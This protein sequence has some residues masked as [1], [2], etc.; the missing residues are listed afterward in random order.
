MQYGLRLASPSLDVLPLAAIADAVARAAATGGDTPFHKPTYQGKFRN[1]LEWVV[2]DARE[3][4]LAVTDQ[5]GKPGT[6]DEAI[7]RAKDNG[8]YSEVSK[9][10][11]EEAAS[12]DVDLDA[13]HALCVY[14]TL[15]NLNDWAGEQGN[16]FAISR[17][18]W[19]DERGWVEPNNAGF[20]RGM[21]QTSGEHRLESGAKESALSDEACIELASQCELH[22]EDW[23]DLTALDDGEYGAYIVSEEGVIFRKWEEHYIKGFPKDEKQEIRRRNRRSPSLTFPCTPKQ[24]LEFV[25][26]AF[27]VLWGSFS[28]P[29]AFRQAVTESA[30]V[31]AEPQGQSATTLSGAAAKVAPGGLAKI[32]ILSVPWPLPP[33]APTLKNILDELPKWVESACLKVGRPGKGPDGSHLWNPAVLAICLATKTPQKKWA[34]GK[35]ALTNFL[36]LNFSDYFAEWT[37]KSQYL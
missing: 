37:E 17:V 31:P 33:N 29:D 10:S 35:G 16:E 11:N 22:L 21:R 7:Q 30:Q 23:T 8:T 13:T 36:R 32:E 25:N 9:R 34:V 6:F 2:T 19:I 12:N 26:K 1:L 28:V 18:G 20:D 27:C 14:T 5:D 3:G 4:R 15:K 24:L